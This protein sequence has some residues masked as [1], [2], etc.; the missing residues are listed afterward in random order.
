MNDE[1]QRTTS[2]YLI[3]LNNQPTN[4]TNEFG[5]TKT[6]TYLW[7][8]SSISDDQNL[9][10]PRYSVEQITPRGEEKVRH[11]R[12]N[13]IHLQRTSTDLWQNNDRSSENRLTSSC[14]D[15]TG[16]ASDLF[17][18]SDGRFIS[19]S[20]VKPSPPPFLDKTIIGDEWKDSLSPNQQTS[21]MSTENPITS[22]SDKKTHSTNEIESGQ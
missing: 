1:Q 16:S 10:F 3:E 18:L 9:C 6:I 2:V 14:Q 19:I 20:I 12:L 13:F 15:L 5:L 7:K 17:S 8:N 4:V 21:T 22:P 11:R